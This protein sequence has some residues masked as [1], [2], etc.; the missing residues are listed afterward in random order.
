MHAP[1]SCA[2]SLCFVHVD[3]LCMSIS[4]SPSTS[5]SM[6]PCVHVRSL[7]VCV[8]ARAGGGAR[9]ERREAGGLAAERSGPPRRCSLQ[10]PLASLLF[11]RL[12]RCCSLHAARLLPPPASS[13]ACYMLSFCA[14]S[15][16]LR[17]RCR[18]SRALH[19]RA[20]LLAAR[21]PLP[22]PL[23]LSLSLTHTHTHTFPLSRCPLAT[24]LNSIRHTH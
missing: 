22:L 11:T 17:S 3:V 20:A 8:C 10:P 6:C 9:H 12:A 21:L 24:V 16:L 15:C 19:L 14:A 18:S 1:G 4:T 23:S 2:V 13:S 7:C 5:T